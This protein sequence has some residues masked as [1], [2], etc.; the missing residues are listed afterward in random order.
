MHLGAQLDQPGVG[1]RLL[2]GEVERLG[3]VDLRGRCPRQRVGLV[4]RR[5]RGRAVQQRRTFGLW[6]VVRHP[7]P[8]EQLALSDEYG[9]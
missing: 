9:A 2:A 4:G 6:F 1:V 3:A 8:Q 5:Y 7:V